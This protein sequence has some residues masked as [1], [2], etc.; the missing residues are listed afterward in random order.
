MTNFFDA[1]YG[2][3]TKTYCVENWDNGCLRYCGIESNQWEHRL[4]RLGAGPPSRD[5]HDR[6]ED[7]HMSGYHSDRNDV[8]TSSEFCAL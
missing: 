5:E 8:S 3:L 1:R 6:I 4:F 7:R 2:L